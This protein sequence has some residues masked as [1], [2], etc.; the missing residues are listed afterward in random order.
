MDCF[1]CVVVNISYCT[2]VAKSVGAPIFH[3]NGD[4]ADAGK[5]KTHSPSIKMQT[6]IVLN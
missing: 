6:E 3:V 5:N 2:D 1:I 4:D